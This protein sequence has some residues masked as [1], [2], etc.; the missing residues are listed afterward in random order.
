MGSRHL[1]SALKKPRRIDPSA[2]STRTD[3][4][5]TQQFNVADLQW[6]V[7]SYTLMLASLILIG[8]SLGD[9]FG[10]LFEEFKQEEEAPPPAAPSPA[11][12]PGRGMAKPRGTGSAPAL[13]SRH[14]LRY[15]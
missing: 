7:N 13:M 2:A 14:A 4:L 1:P 15:A 11:D 9:R 6:I 5:P 8:G 10:H 12:G 3:A